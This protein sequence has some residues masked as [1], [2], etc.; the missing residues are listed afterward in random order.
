MAKLEIRKGKLVA[1]VREVP[2]KRHKRVVKSQH[3][4]QQPRPRLDDLYDPA[5]DDPEVAQIAT[6]ALE[7]EEKD[8]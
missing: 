7:G 8:Q 4:R 5:D 2:V 3:P 1:D 6:D